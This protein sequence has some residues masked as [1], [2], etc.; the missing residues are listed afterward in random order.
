MVSYVLSIPLS[1]QY[2]LNFAGEI[3]TCCKSLKIKKPIVYGFN[4]VSELKYYQRKSER[5]FELILVLQGGFFVCVIL[6]CFVNF[7]DDPY[8]ES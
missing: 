7:L 8:Y 1:F 4:Y 6:G 2:P 3:I 5:L